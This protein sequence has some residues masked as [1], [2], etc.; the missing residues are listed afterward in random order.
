MFSALSEYPLHP[1]DELHAPGEAMWIEGIGWLGQHHS[2]LNEFWEKGV[3]YFVRDYY[4]H[5]LH[6]T[7]YTAELNSKLNTYECLRQASLRC[8]P[9]PP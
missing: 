4:I 8:E 9:R 7:S 1:D 2:Y 6:D 3:L 5:V